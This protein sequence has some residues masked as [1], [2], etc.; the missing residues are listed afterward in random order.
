MSDPAKYRTKEELEE[1]KDKDPI[2]QVLQTIMANNYATETEIEAINEK[3]KAEVE[4]CVRFAED[5][6]Y[7]ADDELYKDIYSEENYPY[8]V[9]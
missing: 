6:P 4:E 9:D 7:P 1:Y 3:V 5:S 8:I 2:T